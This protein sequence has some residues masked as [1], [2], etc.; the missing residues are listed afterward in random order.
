MHLRV[1]HEYYKNQKMCD[2][3][4]NIYLHTIKLVFKCFMTQDMCDKTVNKCLFV[5]GS[6]PYQ[7]NTRSYAPNN[8][9]QNSRNM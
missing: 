5:F 3:A 4:V 7:N 8:T 1:V 9:F 2:K 6:I